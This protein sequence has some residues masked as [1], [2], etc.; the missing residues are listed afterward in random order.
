MAGPHGTRKEI[1][2]LGKL[3]FEIA[4][5]LGA[6]PNYY[7]QWKKGRSRRHYDGRPLSRKKT[8]LQTQQESCPKGQSA[9]CQQFAGGHLH[10]RL[11]DHQRE[12]LHEMKFLQK[13]GEAVFDIGR[14]QER[15]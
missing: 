5:I 9:K 13:L 2:G 4:E 11:L 3:F 8:K 15:G 7:E 12:P 14:A 6:L 10:S 1:Q